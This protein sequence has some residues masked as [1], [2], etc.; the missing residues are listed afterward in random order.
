MYPNLLGPLLTLVGICALGLG[1]LLAR[2]AV[3]RRLA[4]RQVARRKTEA[5]LVITGSVLGT[6]IIIGA[7]VVGDTLNHSV[8]Q[9]A[10]RTLGPVDE[11]VLAT[12]PAVAEAAAV[13]LA[14]LAGDP[15]IDGVLTARVDQA[16]AIA[17]TDSGKAAEP[18]VLAWDV[19]FAEASEFGRDGGDPGLSGPSPAPGTVVL[20][21]PLAD[22]LGVTAGDQV[23]FFLYGAAQP[24]RVD[25]VLPERGLAGTGLGATT[26]NNA[27]L[28][29][30]LLN[31]TAEATSREPRIVTFVSNRGD[32][33]GG[34]A[35]TAHVTGLIQKELGTAADAVTVETPKRDILKEAQQVGDSLG[36]LFLMIGSFSI[37][38]G[39][40]LLVNIFVMLAEER[41]SQL[42]MLR[43]IGMKRSRLVGSLTLEGSAY[44]VAA[45]VPGVLL[46]LGVGYGVALAAAQIFEGWT[47]DGAGLDISFAFTPTSLVNGVAMGLVI[48]VATIFLTS[49]RISR[50]NVISAIRDLPPSTSQRT[51]RGLLVGGTALAV[52]LGVLSVPAV[53]SSAPVPTLLL[54]ALALLCAVPLMR[55]RLSSRAATTVA[56][57]GV[58]VWSL[59]APVVRPAIFDTPSMAIYVV[60]GTLVAFAG[61]TLVSQN[62]QLLLRPARRLLER[63]SQTGLAVRL[64]V[65][66][67]LAKRFRTG[68]TLVMYTLITLV[69]VLLAE[70]SGMINKSVDTNVVNATAG[71]SLRLDLNPVSADRAL[72]ALA[73]GS[74]RHQI[75]GITPL[76]SAMAKT[77]DPGGRTTA[78]LRANIVGVPDGALSAM[79]FDRHLEP[80]DSDAAVWDL[81]AADTD[82]VVLDQMFGAEGGPNG[83][84]YEP[85]DTMT[86][87]DPYTGG[88]TTKKIAGVLN[89]GLSFYAMSGEAANAWPVITSERAVREQ[90]GAAAQ[91]SAALVRT[92]VGTS[93]ERL[94]PQLQGEYLADSLV[95]TAI[96]ANIRRMFKANTAFFQLM[97][98]FLALGLLVGVTGLGVVMVR[99]VRERRRTIGVLRALGFRSRTVARSF[100]FESGLV[101]VEGIVLGAVLGVLTTWLMYQKSAAFDGVRAGFPIV[102]GTIGL[103]AAATFVAS[104]LATIGPARRAAQVKPALAVRVAE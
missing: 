13:R 46:G 21:Q 14:H 102:W 75:E 87:T 68:A 78:P 96:A 100:L 30:G 63:P 9:D 31:I 44:A 50:F 104:L 99:A 47:E 88:T 54:P 89:S 76:V 73:N 36:A 40:L 67:P 64:A 16:A 19:D 39:A 24:L 66:Y 81:L 38:A 62:Q 41:K 26:N 33:E 42:G 32:V 71:F 20:N 92:P 25:R 52:L 17:V 80:L 60:S 69:L 12:D 15:D 93:P 34:N 53:A 95:A 79:T 18:R 51:R 70:I 29:E 82:Y 55:R 59:I 77:S 45:I 65:A 11:R 74:F 43:A 35:L 72:T 58:L 91:V 6:A 57:G 28:P 3:S 37:I 86:V 49:V 83:R 98:G 85:G 22:S 48:A 97:Q 1:V 10:Y 94:A 5:A 8:R 84:F 90:F 23:T 4:V 2:Q 7:L 101:A 61:V 56:A 27:F 103:L